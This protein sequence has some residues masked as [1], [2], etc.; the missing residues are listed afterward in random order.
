MSCIPSIIYFWLLTFIIYQTY[1][2]PPVSVWS[3]TATKGV[4]TG[5]GDGT[6]AWLGG[7]R[8]PGGIGGGAA[9][10]IS[11]TASWPPWP[12]LCALPCYA[13]DALC[14]TQDECLYLWG[15]VLLLIIQYSFSMMMNVFQRSGLFFP[16]NY[17]IMNSTSHL[18]D[19]SFSFLN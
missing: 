8:Q 2:Q 10:G 5:G 16:L 9:H 6:S 19:S 17:H 15:I 12:L 18:H 3:N 13:S 11:G 1:L 14:L 4:G 7:W